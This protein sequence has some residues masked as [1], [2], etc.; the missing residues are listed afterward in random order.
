M[1]AN[2]PNKLAW[3]GFVRK[4]MDKAPLLATE[5]IEAGL[6]DRIEYKRKVTPIDQSRYVHDPAKPHHRR[7][8]DHVPLLV[9]DTEKES[10]L[11]TI[12]NSHIINLPRYRFARNTEDRRDKLRKMRAFNRVDPND[13]S[14]PH[15]GVGIVYLPSQINRGDGQHRASAVASALTS[16]GMSSRVQT[17]V[18]RIDSPGGDAIASETIW[19]AVK[20]VQEKYKKP[21]IVSFGN[22][23]A[24]GG[25]YAASPAQKIFASA[26]T[27][28]G[29]I[30]VANIR[31]YVPPKTMEQ[32]G[33]HVGQAAFS[34]SA[35]SSTLFA[36]A[37]RSRMERLQ[38]LSGHVYDVF[39]KHVAEGRRMSVEE[40][41]AIAGGR[42]FS[43]KDALSKGL[44]DEIG[45][46]QAAVKYAT[47]LAIKRK[48]K[49][50]KGE[51]ID[52]SDIIRNVLVFPQ[53]KPLIRRILEAQTVDDAFGEM[54]ASIAAFG[55]SVSALMMQTAIGHVEERVEHAADIKLE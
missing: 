41:Q 52:E 20:T 25:Y 33:V 17:V 3:T 1:V 43:G 11:N 29:S 35:K 30:G 27:I 18:F 55:R 14:N 34:E 47:Q 36:E 39:I 50:L 12:R 46:M 26:A 24:S 9:E 28:T 4:L 42:V 44:V 10:I 51:V 15:I 16:A 7:E 38:Q 13:P 40:V 22:V 21:V 32:Y 2:L 19:E 8:H 6:I 31:F 23:S 54:Q 49:P 53:N 5:C 45:G 37:D 48:F